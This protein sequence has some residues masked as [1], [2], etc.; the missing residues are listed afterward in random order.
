MEVPNLVQ[1]AIVYFAAA[2][3]FRLSDYFSPI[4]VD[5]NLRELSEKKNRPGGFHAWR[6][7][8]WPGRPEKRPWS[9]AAV[10]DG[11]VYGS[12]WSHHINNTR[13]YGELPG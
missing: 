3:N 7:H 12:R 13:V 11:G 10:G 5:E 2:L 8:P 1:R 6:L 9:V 4:T